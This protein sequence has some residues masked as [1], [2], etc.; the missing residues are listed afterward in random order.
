MGG[1]DTDKCEKTRAYYKNVKVS[2]EISLN[3]RNGTEFR[4]AFRRAQH[5]FLL[6]FVVYCVG[7]QDN[8]EAA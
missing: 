4:F 6:E 1:A 7:K 3:T 2:Y 5:I 8:E